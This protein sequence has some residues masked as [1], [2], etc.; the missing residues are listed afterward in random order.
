MKWFFFILLLANLGLFLLIYPQKADKI[1]DNRLPDVGELYLYEEL[2]VSKS[3]DTDAPEVTQVPGSE[4]ADEEAVSAPELPDNITANQAVD[5][6]PEAQRQTGLATTERPAGS[7]E[8]ISAAGQ[9][10]TPI[11][12]EAEPLAEEPEPVAVPICRTV[13]NLE[14]RSD[15]EIVSVNL[16]AMGLKPELQSETRN[17]EAGIW[18]LIPPQSSRRKAIN[19]AKSLEQDGVTDLWRFTSG[20]LVHAISLGLFRNLSRAEIRKKKIESLGYEVITQPRYR[21]KTK[22]WLYFQ[23]DTPVPENENRWSDLLEKYP[24]LEI[25]E[26]ACR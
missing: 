22:Y 4:K 19:I 14:T 21:Q 16:R 10:D 26:A 20:D 9:P 1:V 17:E 5:Q 6:P 23:E 15:A 3:A 7:G 8:G 2:A 18:V 11:T 25:N 12:G 24:G 13:G